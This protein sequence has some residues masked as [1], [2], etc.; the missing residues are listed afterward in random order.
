MNHPIAGLILAVCCLSFMTKSRATE[1][2]APFAAKTVAERDA[3]LQAL[4][5]ERR[6]P[7]TA[8]TLAT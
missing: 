5:N 4:E 6:S 2:A 7:E 1:A 8:M 3:A